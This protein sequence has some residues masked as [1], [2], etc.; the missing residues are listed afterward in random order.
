[1]ARE[2][3]RILA[4]VISL[5]GMGTG[6]LY[7]LEGTLH[8]SDLWFGLPYP[9]DLPGYKPEGTDW[10]SVGVGAGVL[11]VGTRFLWLLIRSY[12]HERPSSPAKVRPESQRDSVC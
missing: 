6:I 1:M 7:L 8:L 3:C 2:A 4:I 12:K 11:L 9:W 5:V 10:I